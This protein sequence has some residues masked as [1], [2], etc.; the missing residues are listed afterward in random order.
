MNAEKYTV[1]YLSANIYQFYSNGVR[2]SFEMFIIYSPH[3]NNTYNLGFGVWNEILE[4]VDDSVEIRNGDTDKNDLYVYL[5]QKYYTMDTIIESD[6]NKSEKF[7][8]QDIEKIRV[9]FDK[10]SDKM[11]ALLKAYPVPEEFR[12]KQN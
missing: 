8:A 9:Y 10:K 6:K 7:S 4:E 11:R 3:G 12:K 5:N 1:E 2:G